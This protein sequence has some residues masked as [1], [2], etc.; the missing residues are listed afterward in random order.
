MKLTCRCSLDIIA[1]G[2]PDVEDK[3]RGVVRMD[4]I[5]IFNSNWNARMCYLAHR[6]PQ[7][8]YYPYMEFFYFAFCNILGNCSTECQEYEHCDPNSCRHLVNYEVCWRIF[9]HWCTSY[10]GISCHLSCELNRVKFLLYCYQYISLIEACLFVAIPVK[11]STV[12]SPVLAEVFFMLCTHFSKLRHQI[13]LISP[14]LDRQ[15]Y[16]HYHPGVVR[17]RPGSWKPKS[18]AGSNA[19]EI[20][21]WNS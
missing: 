4:S 20:S 11:N 13:F 16:V 3:S 17:W 8:K 18:C 1:F 6:C 5:E 10:I 9:L 7:I 15:V 2:V 21:P 14:R 12:C 19:S